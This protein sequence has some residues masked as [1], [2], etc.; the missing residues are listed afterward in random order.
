M[1]IGFEVGVEDDV[2]I[3]EGLGAPGTILGGGI[4]PLPG[5]PLLPPLVLGIEGG[6]LFIE[7]FIPM[8]PP[9]GP[10]DIPILFGPGIPGPPPMGPLTIPMELGGMFMLPWDIPIGPL[11]IP[12][13]IELGPCGP[14]DIIPPI[15]LGPLDM[16]PII[17][18]GGP[19]IGP[20]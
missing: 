8:G 3:E 14:L 5:G 20:I 13:P 19:F 11:F 4:C 10:L 9:G 12:I 17:E 2:G 7:P 18:F 16:G 1:V 6:P 15:E